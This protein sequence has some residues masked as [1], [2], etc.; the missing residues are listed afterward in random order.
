M[1]TLRELLRAASRTFALGIER[2]PGVLGDAVMVAYLLL[3]VSDYLED[4]EEMPPDQKVA[5]LN[6]WD[7]VLA[8][9]ADVA[10][11]TAS[12]GATD[13]SNPDAAVAEHAAEVIARLRALPP[14]VQAPII[15]NV[16]DSTQ[17]MA[18]W[19]ARGP[20]VDDEADM[21]DYM[22]E[23]AGRVGYLLTHLFA[24]YS[25]YVRL[26]KDALM[27]LAR[28][29]GLALQTVNVIRGLREDYRRGWIFVPRSFCRLVNI[30]REDLFR[31]EHRA[32]AIQVLDMLADK[33]ERHLLAAMA[34]LKALPPWQHSIRLF[35]IFPLM[36][37]VRTLAISR[38]NHSVLESEAKISREEVKRIVRDTT[39]WGWSNLWL[40]HYYRQLSTVSE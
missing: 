19:V 38:K 31:P 3:R 17:G 26:H 1:T 5:L 37:A 9:R 28:E 32:Q 36:F 27:P 11:L 18:R 13:A 25:Y 12:L 6:L 33:A 29:F 10:Q 35:C 23:V 21:D 16:R 24:W 40:D 39:L 30:S 2:L 20:V 8:G 14:E 22:H 4:N 7:E 34:Y 15:S